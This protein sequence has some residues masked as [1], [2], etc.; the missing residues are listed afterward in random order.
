MAVSDP[1]PVENEAS[2]RSLLQSQ[3]STSEVDDQSSV[4]ML[5]QLGAS[6]PMQSPPS[7]A[8]TAAGTRSVMVPAARPV[9]ARLVG[10]GSAGSRGGLGAGWAS[11]RSSA[12]IPA[13]LG[14]SRCSGKGSGCFLDRWTGPA[15]GGAI[16]SRSG[17]RDASPRDPAGVMSDTGRGCTA[18]R[19]GGTESQ[20]ASAARPPCFLSGTGRGDVAHGGLLSPAGPGGGGFAL[21]W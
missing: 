17:E 13:G 15:G 1:P 2:G 5:Q 12:W 6:D 19:E 11:W 20:S 9:L 18:Q 4:L 10:G 14:R 16:G 8:F 21:G 3:E 7:K